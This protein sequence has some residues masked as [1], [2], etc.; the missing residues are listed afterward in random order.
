MTT[1]SD[2]ELDDWGDELDAATSRIPPEDQQRFQDALVDLEK[3]SKDAV[4]REWGLP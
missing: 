1:A 3:E 2:R 4:K